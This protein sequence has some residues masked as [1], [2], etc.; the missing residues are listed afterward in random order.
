MLLMLLGGIL[1]LLFS[2]I[3]AIDVDDVGRDRTVVDTVGW[4]LAF[5][6]DVV[7]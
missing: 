7:G 3:L 4:D 6:V 1:L 5:V 2:K